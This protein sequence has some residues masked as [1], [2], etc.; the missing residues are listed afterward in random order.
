MASRM[1]AKGLQNASGS[2]YLASMTRKIDDTT[3]DTHSKRHQRT[4]K[5]K[6]RQ[7]PMKNQGVLML[8]GPELACR[9]LGLRFSPPPDLP[10]F[11]FACS[12]LENGHAL[13]ARF[14]SSRVCACPPSGP[15]QLGLRLIRTD[16][17]RER[18]PSSPARLTFLKATLKATQ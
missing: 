14:P 9:I 4:P 2:L 18:F 17:L 1:A 7:K 8:F 12:S 6:N 16:T 11:R 3:Q 10:R 13:E 15:P 5:R